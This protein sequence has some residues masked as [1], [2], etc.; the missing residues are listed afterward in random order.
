MYWR[1]IKKRYFQTISNFTQ[2][3]VNILI[4]MT[5]NIEWH[6]IGAYQAKEEENEAD[7]I[8]AGSSLG[9]ERGGNLIG[10]QI[11]LIHIL[12]F[13]M[14]VYLANP[15]LSGHRGIPIVPEH[16]HYCSP[17]QTEFQ[18]KVTTNW[19]MPEELIG[20]MLSMMTDRCQLVLQ[21]R[22]RRHDGWRH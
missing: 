7:N 2:N 11:V 15:L 16:P 18:V 6:R 4:A 5:L 10:L 9:L 14:L 21:G 8:C 17:E 22:R 19:A 3:W 12:L 1:G 13:L 20:I